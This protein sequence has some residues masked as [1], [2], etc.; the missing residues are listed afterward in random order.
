MKALSYKLLTLIDAAGPI[1]AQVDEHASL[2]PLHSG[3]WS[4]KQL[5]G[6]LIDSASNNHQRF[7][8]ASLQ[9]QL[10][11]PGYDQNGN[12][13]VQHFQHASWSM[14]V[15]LWHSYNQF[16]AHVIAHLPESKLQTAC[17]IGVEN[18]VTLEFLATD[19][20]THLSHHLAQMG[21]ATTNEPS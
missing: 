3:G 7:V 14:L 5:V 2:Q 21:V 4:R 6:H 12:V 11:F 1:F 18:P 8:R 20:V 13:R 15:S 9:P 10:N 16:L 19:Y 17:R